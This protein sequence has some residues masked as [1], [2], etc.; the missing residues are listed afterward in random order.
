MH[1]TLQVTIFSTSCRR[2]AAHHCNNA[3]QTTW[4]GCCRCDGSCGTHQPLCSEQGARLRRVLCKPWPKLRW[5]PARFP[6]CCVCQLLAHV[7]ILRVPHSVCCIA[8]PPCAPHES[9]FAERRGVVVAQ[10]G[11]ILAAHEHC[12]PVFVVVHL[13]VLQACSWVSYSIL[14]QPV[15]NMRTL[16]CV[17]R[18]AATK[19]Q[20]ACSRCSHAMTS[21]SAVKSALCCL[22]WCK[23]NEHACMW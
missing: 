4:P 2:G 19:Q 13:Q 9:A 17:R 1:T 15:P 11:H 12:L 8:K 20:L 14:S 23:A 22:F 6:A 16:L 18:A 21:T 7:L 10:V 3:C 5:R